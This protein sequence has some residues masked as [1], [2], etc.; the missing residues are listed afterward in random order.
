MN[1]MFI[2]LPLPMESD[3]LMIPLFVRG[4]GRIILE[5]SMSVAGVVGEDSSL[6]NMI[7]QED[8][9]CF[10]TDEARQM[11]LYGRENNVL[12]SLWIHAYPGGKILPFLRCK[13]RWGAG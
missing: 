10:L 5:H 6:R 4:L 13:N 8:S 9:S 12:S 7:E 2:G 3:I 1:E 11:K